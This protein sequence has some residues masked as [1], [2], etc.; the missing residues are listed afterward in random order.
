[1]HK[2]SQFARNILFCSLLVAASPFAFAQEAAP[3]AP[4]KPAV[5]TPM[6]PAQ[7]YGKLLTGMEQ[8]FVG[9][10][11]AMPEDKFNFAPPTTAGEFKGA[12]HPV[13]VLIGDGHWRRLWEHPSLHG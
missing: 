10:A 9:A 1:M 13:T 8:E 6:Q 12:L 2:T 5:G 4:P 11:E 7:V 3:A